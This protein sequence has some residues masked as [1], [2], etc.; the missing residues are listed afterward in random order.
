M[1]M[2][3]SNASSL[4][5]ATWRGDD[6]TFR[7]VSTDSRTLEAG[8]LF[9]ALQGPNFDGHD[10]VAAAK[11]RGA[12]A[13][14]VTR[15]LDDVALPQ[16]QVRDT[17]LALGRL[18]RYWRDRFAGR[19]VAVTG[20]NGKTTV[21]ELIASILDRQAPTLA[22]AGNLNNDIGLPLT[23]FQLEDTHRF[24]VLELGAN[25]PGEIAYLAS[26]ARPDVAVV[27]NAGP[28]HLEGFGSLEGVANAKG[29]L[30]QALAGEGVA[31]INAD[32]AFAPLWRSFADGARIVDFGIDHPAA[33]SAKLIS[34]QAGGEVTIETPAGR[35][36][37]RLALS[38]RHN[39][40][41]A[42]A[43]T[44]AAVALEIP[45]AVI[46]EGL[47]AMRPVSGRLQTQQGT[48]GCRVIDDTYNANPASLRAALDVLAALPGEHWL[49]LGDMGELGPDSV[50][51]HRHAGR[52]ALESGVR[53]LFTL[54]EL[55]GEAAQAFGEGASGH[56]SIEALVG[57]VTQAVHADVTLLV[58]GSRAMR[59]ERVVRALTA[60]TAAGGH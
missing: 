53:R 15:L 57:A 50:E 51:L 44:A 12:A 39:L 32:D 52:A 45:P 60:S 59:M 56:V 25:H 58:K 20:S 10:Y 28:A 49:V 17:R 22:T 24:A 7:G 5:E 42:L 47:A 55:A 40:M 16:M 37:T 2:P 27:N 19:V 48:A 13:A 36:H 21:K 11:E 4:L 46:A 9:V 26:I 1:T 54:G 41:N 14:A 31:V 3:L 30:F 34:L 18:A 8:N 6:V 35:V 38:G 33:V 23:L 29:E 43:A